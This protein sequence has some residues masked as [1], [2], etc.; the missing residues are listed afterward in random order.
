M[1]NINEVLSAK[2]F[3][4]DYLAKRL[5]I[6]IIPVGLGIHLF[7]DK[8]VWVFFWM[9]SILAITT[10]LMKYSKCR[11]KHE[12]FIMTYGDRYIAILKQEIDQVGINAVVE[13]YW[14]GLEPN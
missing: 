7:M 12:E 8:R 11:K 5:L 13:R 1:L 14:V 9:F 6:F 3:W 2:H 4:T 10:E